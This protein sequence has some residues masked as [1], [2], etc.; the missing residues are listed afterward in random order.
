MLAELALALEAGLFEDTHRGGLRE[1]T[2]T[3]MRSRSNRSKPYSTS[4][5]GGREAREAL[6]EPS[7][8]QS[9]SDRRALARAVDAPDRTAHRRDE[10]GY[11]RQAEAVTAC[12]AAAS[13]SAVVP[14]EDAPSL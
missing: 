14:L 13:R 10:T 2:C 12:V 11:G 7:E 8:R 6:P 5:I 3:S 4:V 9:H 1:K